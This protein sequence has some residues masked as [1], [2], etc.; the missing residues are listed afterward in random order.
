MR[1]TASQ[2]LVVYG[3]TG[4]TGKLIAAH[5]ATRY[6]ADGKLRWALAGRSREK[7]ASVRDSIGLPE[8]FPLVV[9]NADDPA[10]L[11]RLAEQTRVCI[12]AVGPYQ[13]YGSAMVAAC[14][15]AGTDY[16]DLC[17]E[18]AWMRGMI[19][20]HEKTARSS[21]AR[22]VFSCG[23]DSIPFE[24]GVLAVQRAAEAATGAP[25]KHVKA[26]VLKLRGT[27]SGG[28]LASLRANVASAADPAV[29]ALLTDHFSLTP[30][31]RGPEQ[32]D[33]TAPQ[34]DAALGVWLAPFLMAT[35]NTRIVHR[36]N[37]LQHH[38]YGADF[39]YEEMLVAGRGAQGEATAKAIAGA[40]AGLAKAEGPKPGEGPSLE[41]RQAGSYEL[42]FIGSA[43]PSASAP[44]GATFKAIVTGDRDPGYGSTSKMVAETA[45]CLLDETNGAPGGIWT[46]GALLG[47]RLIERLVNHAGL[48]VTASRDSE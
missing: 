3:A 23:F 15:A 17:G 21:G 25:L 12:S 16:V 7:L 27:F 40:N 36:S 4:F 10:S 18:P 44:S 38:R 43:P 11:Q 37:Y 48:T 14:A 33:T 41:E 6:G 28:T 31:F 35:I 29:R 42:L 39:V 19:D 1:T 47:E 8:S 26:R 22:I 24:L 2:D 9:A 32:P 13:L 34:S 45:L 30:D 20:A 5:L 46:P